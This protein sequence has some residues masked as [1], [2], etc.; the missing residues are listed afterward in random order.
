M[1][2][3]LLSWERRKCDKSSEEYAKLSFRAWSATIGMQT[4]AAACS[5]ALP[6][7]YKVSND[8]EKEYRDNN[9]GEYV[10]ER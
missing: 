2:D 3:V 4:W 6:A 8:S 5:S 7:E 1:S 9:G 10:P